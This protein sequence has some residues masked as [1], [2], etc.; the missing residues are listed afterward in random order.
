MKLLLKTV[1]DGFW[2]VCPLT[3]CQQT[4]GTA[5]QTLAACP[6]WTSNDGS[7]AQTCSTHH[8]APKVRV[9]PHLHGT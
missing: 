5:V 1:S 8:K 9:E 2:K 4:G 6:Q 7:P 3:T